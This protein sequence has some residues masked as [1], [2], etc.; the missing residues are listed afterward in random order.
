M[1]ESPALRPKDVALLLLA[2]GD[3]LPRQ[4]ARD[5]QSDL[6]GNALKSRIL[7][8]LVA[9]DPEPEQVET[10]LA[11]IVEVLGPPTGPTRAVAVSVLEEW[12]AACVAPEFVEWL[13]AQAV[14][15]GLASTAGRAAVKLAALRPHSGGERAAEWPSADTIAEGGRRGRKPRQTAESSDPGTA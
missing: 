12:R 5:Q 13:L 1:M 9:L 6:H 15:A 4:R 3:L 11:Q 2:S 10:T 8:E 14:Q 7:K